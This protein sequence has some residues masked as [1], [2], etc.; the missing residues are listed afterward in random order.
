MD[1]LL[2]AVVMYPFL[3]LLLYALNEAR[4]IRWFRIA[5]R[6]QKGERL[7]RGYS[8]ETGCGGILTVAAVIDAIFV[9]FVLISRSQ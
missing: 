5:S 2:I 4:I 3:A 1:V 6:V 7:N 9:V 8:K